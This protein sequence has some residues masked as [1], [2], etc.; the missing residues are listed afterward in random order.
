MRNIL[1]SY[2]LNIKCDIFSRALGVA[3]SQHR[4][5][6]N[7][8]CDEVIVDNW[9]KKILLDIFGQIFKNSYGG[10]SNVQYFPMKRTLDFRGSF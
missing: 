10:L 5:Q 7:I 4:M 9:N 8:T 6:M 2:D 1:K 3:T